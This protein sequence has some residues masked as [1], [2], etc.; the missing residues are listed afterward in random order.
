MLLRPYSGKT[1]PVDAAA[2]LRTARARAGLS[3]TA[4]ARMTGTSRSALT[5]LEAGRRSPTVRTMDALLRA[6]DLQVRIA[7]EPYLA[8]V[9]AALDEALAGTAELRA[10]DVHRFA[11]ALEATGVRWAVDG[12]TAVALHGLAV[13]QLFPCLAVVDDGVTRTWLRD[14]WAKGQDRH[15]FSLAP[16][17]EE[18]PETVRLYVREPVWTRLGFVQL[19]F[20]DE[21]GV[22]VPVV[23]GGVTLPVLPLLEVEHTAPQLA[24][25]LARLRQRRAA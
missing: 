14:I 15:G 19:R 18:P 23:L 1:A 5:E 10:Q 11:G 24:D 2:L 8:D 6:C 17:W 20:V 16:H 25:L 13:V 3:V 21:L 12:A 9:D 4:L 22:T 7:L